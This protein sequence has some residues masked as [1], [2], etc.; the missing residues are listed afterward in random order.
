MINLESYPILCDNRTSFAQVNRYD[1]IV[2]VTLYCQVAPICE[3]DHRDDCPLYIKTG[4][5][6]PVAVV[7]DRYLVTNLLWFSEVLIHID[8]AV[9]RIGEMLT[10]DI[11]PGVGFLQRPVNSPLI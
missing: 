8:A 6:D 3:I 10:D 5:D 7:E 9:F 4:S 2:S 1:D 11:N